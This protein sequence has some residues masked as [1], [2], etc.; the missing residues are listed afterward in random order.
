MPEIRNL[1]E[2]N[3]LFEFFTA[4]IDA[5]PSRDVPLEDLQKLISGARESMTR[6]GWPVLLQH[7]FFVSLKA[8]LGL[9]P[10]GPPALC[11]LIALLEVETEFS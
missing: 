8:I 9:R 1:A 4:A 10:Q 7:N 2:E 11:Q 3:M 5:S 6:F